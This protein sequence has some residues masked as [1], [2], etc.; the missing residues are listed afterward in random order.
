M[1]AVIGWP[2]RQGHVPQRQTDLSPHTTD[3]GRWLASPD[4]LQMLAISSAIWSGVSL[5]PKL[6]TELALAI[7]QVDQQHVVHQV[8]VRRAAGDLLVV[9]AIGLGDLRDLLRRAGQADHARMEVGDV[10]LQHLPACRARD[11]R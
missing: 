4:T 7:H 2:L 11:R 9:H 5:G 1:P 3:C 10:V 8:L 6:V